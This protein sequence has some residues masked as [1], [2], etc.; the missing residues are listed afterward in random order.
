[1]PSGDRATK[2]RCGL[3]VA[4]LIGVGTFGP[5]LFDI[6]AAVAQT[7]H[8]DGSIEYPLCDKEA[9]PDDVEGA[10]GAHKAASQFFER[11][12]YDRAIQYWNDAYSFDCSKPALLLNLANA[13]EKKGNKRATISI[14]EEYLQRA[15]DTPD[16]DTIE[17]KIANLRENLE[18]EPPPPPVPTPTTEPTD[19][20]PPPPPPVVE[21]RP[22]GVTPWIVAGAGA[23]M[24]V[25]G[26]I[27]FIVGQGKIGDAE[28]TC[29][30]KSNCP[31]DEAIALG[32][33]GR[34]L[35]LV[36]SILGWGGLAV[37]AGG[38]VWQFAFNAPEPVQSSSFTVL[39]VL[40]PG[41]E[42]SAATAG[43]EAGV[44][45]HGTF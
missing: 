36:G 22:F 32:N 31:D 27:L 2:T 39:P 8:P 24:A 16:K 7:V 15:P 5:G 25:P 34:D 12:D 33:D 44:I 35:S 10:K 17:T 42:G 21:E 38:L 29:P 45:V 37:L 1:M 6:R 26:F 19:D 43:T 20:I 23:A 3:S 41:G 30:D 14:L 28:E 40:R 4:I 13:Y 9:S 18:D 11:G